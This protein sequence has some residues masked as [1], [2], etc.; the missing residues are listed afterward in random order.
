MS[1]IKLSFCVPTYNRA[2]Y[3]GQTLASMADQIISGGW[4]DCIEICVSENASTDNTDDVINEFKNIYPLVRLVYSKNN[5][6]LGADSNYLRVV[7]IA[8]GDYCW[9]FGSDDA[10]VPGAISSIF[11]ELQFNYDIILSNR[12]ECDID[13][14]QL[15]KQYW[16]DLNAG[17]CVYNFNDSSDITKYF[18]EARS[19]GALFSYLSSIVVKRTSWNTIK[20]DES[21]IG[22]AYSHVYILLSL[23]LKGTI[24]KYHVEPTVLC[25][26]GNDSF[27]K[28]SLAKRVILDLDGYVL[29]AD[30]LFSDDKV[31]Y[32]LF[33]LVL[34][35][36]CNSSYFK[37]LRS[38][39]KIRLCSMQ[40]DWQ[41]L[42]N[43]YKIL[44][45]LDRKIK[46]IYYIPSFF[47]C[48]ARYAYKAKKYI[49][50]KN[51]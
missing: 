19:L 4:T 2:N 29:L 7:E 3:I 25:R 6:N 36:E 16:L 17:S 30:T 26:G 51:A 28:K 9:L 31:S 46:I 18:Q 13:L 33:L 24:L 42:L 45:G 44:Y 23:M 43:R 39:L 50:G 35:T 11:Q 5:E 37:S 32:N 21:F 49:E 1:D 47:I 14:N 22:T 15:R 38:I 48:F 34:K 8:S 12:I 40:G 27:M 20:F 41:Y 10:L